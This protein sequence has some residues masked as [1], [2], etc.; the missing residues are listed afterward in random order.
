M[1]I[2]IYNENG[3]VKITKIITTDGVERTIFSDLKD[4]E[5]AEVEVNFCTMTRAKK[6]KKTEI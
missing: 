5:V 6:I 1:K 2:K 3:V 4:G